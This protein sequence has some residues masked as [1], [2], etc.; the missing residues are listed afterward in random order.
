MKFQEVSNSGNYLKYFAKEV[1]QNYM[2]E[3]LVWT[4]EKDSKQSLTQKLTQFTWNTLH[5]C[6]C[7]SK[8]KIWAY[9]CCNVWIA[10]FFWTYG[11][12]DFV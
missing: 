11:F 3:F 9:C 12:V 6:L 1:E 10:W 5:Y 4:K 7:K 8:A 2:E